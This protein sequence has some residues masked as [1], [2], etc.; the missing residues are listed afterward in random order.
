L[1]CRC[2]LCLSLFVR[3]PILQTD[4]VRG[5][6]QVDCRPAHARASCVPDHAQGTVVLP[7][8]AQTGCSAVVSQIANIPHII[9]SSG[10]QPA[11]NTSHPMP[12]PAYIVSSLSRSL[13]LS[14]F[15]AACLFPQ[16]TATAMRH[17]QAIAD[18]L[19]RDQ[20]VI[21]YLCYSDSAQILH[22]PQDREGRT[23]H[24]TSAGANDIWLY[25]EAGLG[26]MAAAR[27][28]HVQPFDRYE[29]P[30]TDRHFRVGF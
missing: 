16:I 7:L 3:L 26:R 27:R 30:Q 20:V 14:S 9:R 24:E 28:R 6:R 8:G 21:H 15:T 1:C 29:T 17:V 4:G 18:S 5:A 2:D 25:T 12:M 22:V 11:H 13:R 10:G 19:P 23:A